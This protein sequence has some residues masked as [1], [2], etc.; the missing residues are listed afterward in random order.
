MSYKLALP[1]STIIFR[2]DFFNNKKMIV[3][4]IYCSPSQNSNEFELFLSS[5][6]QLL[7]DVNKR[8]TS[9]SVI[10]GDFHARSSSWWANDINKAEGLKLLSFTSSNGFPQLINKPTHIQTNSPFVY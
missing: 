5:F 9:L 4:V 8:K 10:K 6:E 7:N 3:S 1:K 2:S